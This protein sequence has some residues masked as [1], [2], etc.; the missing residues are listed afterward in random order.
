MQGRP[1]AKNRLHK[2]CEF[3]DNRRRQRTR[4]I[5]LRRYLLHWG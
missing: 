1:P 3:L 5:D 4:C 2:L